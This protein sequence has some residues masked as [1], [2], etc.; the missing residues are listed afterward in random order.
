L[1]GSKQR[2]PDAEEDPMPEHS[3]APL[4]DALEVLSQYG[5]DL[6]NG[7]FN[8]A[9]MVVEALCALGRPDA[10]FPWI[11]AYRPRLIQRQTTAEPVDWSQWRSHLGRRD[12]FAAWS[13][14]FA[15]ELA[16]TPW[17]SVLDRWAARLA[18]GY[19]GAATH[20][21]IRV[22]HAARGLAEAETR[23]RRRELADALASW[24]ASYNE[25]PASPAAA[26]GEFSPRAAL[27]AMPIVPSER[28]PPGNITI[29]LNHLVDLPGFA[30][31]VDRVDLG[32]NLEVAVSELAELFARVYL[33]NAVDTRT[34]IVFVHSVTA[35]HAL[36]NLLPHVGEAT[37]RSLARYAWQVDCR[38]Y[39][40]FGGM[41]PQD[42]IAAGDDDAGALVD[43]AVQNGD[44]HVIKFAEA[45]V[46]RHKIAPSAVYFA[47][48]RHALDIVRR[49]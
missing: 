33:A 4:D 28:R 6:T 2:P 9:P 48:I 40:A 29:A 37:A 1:N 10:V 22:G 25:L 21:A 18:P 17:R 46:A 42:V 43:Q 47:A 16:E 7:N 38:L 30:T 14:L 36:G 15:A 31:A 13:R 12:D 23:V 41:P 45:C 20:G 8:H 3:Y 24:A 49:R 26:P 27:A 32:E 19:S 34:F 35:V 11:E 5:P 44:E 39:A